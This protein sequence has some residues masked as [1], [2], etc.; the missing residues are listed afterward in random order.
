MENRESHASMA[1]HFSELEDPRRYNR[2]HYLRDILVIAI[3]AAIGG[4][5]GWED[6]EL[7]GRTKEKWLKEVVC[8]KLPH[9]IPS[10]DTF[11]RVFDLRLWMPSSFRP[12]L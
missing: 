10:A 12:A 4:A 3:C 11:R 1:G 6:V 7:F 5:D 2:R 9:G 8:L